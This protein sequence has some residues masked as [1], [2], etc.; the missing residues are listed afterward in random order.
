MTYQAALSTLI[1]GQLNIY[2]KQ[3]NKDIIMCKKC[4]I[5]LPEA[6]KNNDIVYAYLQGRGIDHDTISICI[7]NGSIYETKREHHCVFVGYNGAE[8]KYASIRSTTGNIKKAVNNSDKRFS[9]IIPP[10]N[11]NF[12][13]LAIFES[14]V[15][16]LSHITIC[17]L[18]GNLWDGYRLSLE[19]VNSIALLYFLDHHN[20]IN[21]L[22]LFLD[23]DYT[24]KNACD[25]I[26]CELINN[27]RYKHIKIT[28]T[29]PPYGKDLNETLIEIQKQNKKYININRSLPTVNK[30]RED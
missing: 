10:S 20:S 17:K 18:D 6:N 4:P 1:N 2:V 9:F 7:N 19:G 14:V 5:I 29:S 15:D 13:T 24:G 27:S 22:Q 28:A 12:S 3:D 23:N 8:P 30:N 16:L 21:K 26:I 25:R 11:S